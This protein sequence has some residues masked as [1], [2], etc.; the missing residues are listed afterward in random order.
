MA[1]KEDSPLSLFNGFLKQGGFPEVVIN[2]LDLTSYV[3]NLISAILYKDIAR[4]YNIKDPEKI[5][6]MI[7]Y[8]IAN[9]CNNL[10][11]SKLGSLCQIKDFRTVKKYLGYIKNCYLFYFLSGFSFKTINHLRSTKKLYV[12]DNGLLRY[13]NLFN[14][15]NN[16]VYFENLVF[17]ELVKKG[18]TPD[19]YLFYY[20]TKTN[21]EIDFVLKSFSRV[22]Q[23]IQV[24]YDI[25]SKQTEEREIK[26]LLQASNELGCNDLLIITSDI[27]KEVNIEGKVIKFVPFYK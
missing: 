3:D 26:A 25:S 21:R 6:L 24:C 12:V 18:F 8:L 2:N 22:E 14:S 1:K 13:K 16:G 20:K 5:E 15:P 27:E 17:T 19:S 10:N 4:R 9:T 23:L 11:Y 7:S